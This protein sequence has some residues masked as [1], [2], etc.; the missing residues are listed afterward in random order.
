MFTEDCKSKGFAEDPEYVWVQPAAT[1]TITCSDPSVTDP[2][3][4]IEIPERKYT[5]ETVSPAWLALHDAERK[6]ASK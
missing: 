4:V 6:G 5:R 3:I 2:P 1:I